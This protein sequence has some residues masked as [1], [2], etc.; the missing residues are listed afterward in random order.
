[1]TPPT[2]IDPP[3]KGYNLRS[4]SRPTQDPTAP[5]GVPVPLIPAPPVLPGADPSITK[6]DH[7]TV[8]TGKTT[9]ECPFITVTGSNTTTLDRAC[10][11]SPPP[12]QPT[13]YFGSLARDGNDDAGTTDNDTQAADG[14]SQ[15]LLTPPDQDAPTTDAIT[16]IPADNVIAGTRAA[17]DQHDLAMTTALARVTASPPPATTRPVGFTPI[18]LTTI[19]DLWRMIVLQFEQQREQFNQQKTSSDLK[20]DVLSRKLD[21]ATA[22][23]SG[24]LAVLDKDILRQLATLNNDMELCLTTLKTNISGKLDNATTVVNLLCGRIH[25][26]AAD[27]ADICTELASKIN[28]LWTLLS[29]DIKSNFHHIIRTEIPKEQE[30]T[31]T[32][33]IGH[34]TRTFEA[35]LT[36]LETQTTAP[37]AAK[38]RP[39]V[40]DVSPIIADDEGAPPLPA[41]T[42]VSDTSGSTPTTAT[43]VPDPNTHNFTLP[44]GHLGSG[45]GG[46]TPPFQS[47]VRHPTNKLGNSDY[48]IYSSRA[49]F[50]EGHCFRG[51]H[52]PLNPYTPDCHTVRINTTVNGTQPTSPCLGIP[53]LSP[54]ANK[55]Q[56]SGVS[57]FDVEC[58]AIPDYHGKTSGVA[59]LD[60]AFL[61][62]CGFNMISTDDVVTCYNNIIVAHRRICELWFNPT[63]NTYGPQVDRILLK[64]FK[65][66]P[67]LEST[68]TAEVVDFYNRF[69]ELSPSQ[70]LLVLMPFNGIILKNRFEGLCIPGLGTRCYAECSHALMDSLPRLIPRTLSLRINSTLAAVCNESNNGFDCL[71][72]VLEL[73]VPGFNP[74]V[75]IQ[76][77]L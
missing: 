70:H 43:R 52:L 11:E 12:A 40:G 48:A 3:D 29:G 10:I 4:S 17:F 56:T 74:V 66:F 67:K 47:E 28:T 54:L 33:V 68:A 53:I 55:A 1:M 2:S 51:A 19:S 6:P 58:L 31:L 36:A 37:P 75:P 72:Q 45:L 61:E 7:R 18:E 76:T 13:N 42:N 8:S 59:Q 64:S 71:W 73:T 32:K 20:H 25:L 16:N 39:P 15:P 27:R 77:P 69:Q 9:E 49:A 60:A 63:A 35:R 65:L 5:G 62:R 46:P 38:I 30:A 21:H 14:G 41:A 24:S 50:A 44:D 23:L 22:D 57:R 34:V 26:A